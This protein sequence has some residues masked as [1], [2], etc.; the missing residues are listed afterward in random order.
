LQRNQNINYMKHPLTSNIYT[1]I[2]T[3]LGCDDKGVKG[4]AATIKSMREGSISPTLS[5]VSS[6]I[7]ENG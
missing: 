3:L 5:T 2:K 1:V 7:D 4:T 6:V